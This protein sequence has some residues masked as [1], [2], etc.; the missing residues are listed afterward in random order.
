MFRTSG[1]PTPIQR[2][3]Q[4]PRGVTLIELLV[5][6][7]VIAVLFTLIV[8]AIG[9]AREAG[10]RSRCAAN[11]RDI[12]LALI[13]YHDVN[14]RFPTGGWGYLWT[15]IPERGNGPQQPGGWVY[16]LLPYIEHT[17]LYELGNA[18]TGTADSDAYSTRLQTPLS[19]FVCSSRRECR[20]WPISSNYSYARNPF[21]RGNAIAVA[22]SDY[23]ISSGAAD[24]FAL[25]GPSTITE[26]D[27]A[28]YWDTGPT[29]P[30]FCGISHFR[31]SSS[32]KSIIDGASKTYL[33]GEKY[34]PWEAYFDGSSRGDA[35]S[36]YSGFS[37]D[38]YR[39]SG[40][41]ENTSNGGL[42]YAPPLS[43]FE[44]LSNSVGGYAHFGSAHAHGLN[45]AHCDG[46]VSFIAFDISPEIH[47]RAG[48]R[49]DEGAPL[50]SLYFKR[51]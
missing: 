9:S 18:A 51:P 20:T 8:P 31:K 24:V 49:S 10:R 40:A 6:I 2:D 14:R 4:L 48:H 28:N 11:L 12:G 43:D 19:L 50:E 1:S 30:R 25:P 3:P 17:D 35:L 37:Y 15:G 21:P 34:V 45:M 5:T 13:T 39:F 29:T 38:L 32:L 47:F 46:A 23:A 41:L 36:L 7:A 22:R 44:P 27:D 16:S 33:C 42:P 26:G